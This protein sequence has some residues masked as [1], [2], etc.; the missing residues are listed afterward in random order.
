MGNITGNH[1]ITRFIS[2]AS[3]AMTFQEND[4]EAGWNRIIRIESPVGYY[5]L[6]QLQAFNMTMPGIPVTYYGDEIGDPGANDPDNRRMMRFDQLLQQEL[7]VKSVVE[8]L[9]KLRAQ[10]MPLLYGDLD[11]LSCSD[12]HLVYIRRY[13]NQHVIVVFNKSRQGQSITF[14]L[15][16]GISLKN[17]KSMLGHKLI[18]TNHSV[19]INMPAVSVEVIY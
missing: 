17:S 14:N 11:I 4:R 2:L 1:D 10:S 6:M 15:P 9:G 5:R 3:G 19:T 8:R 18:Y 13:F 7:N 12:T 16:D